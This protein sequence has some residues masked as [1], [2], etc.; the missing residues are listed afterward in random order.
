MGV[1]LHRVYFGY[2]KEIMKTLILSLMLVTSVASAQTL[3]V[4]AVRDWTPTDAP[5]VSQ[6]R[7]YVVT[8]TLDGK[9][10]T[11]QQMF[12]LGSQHFS[13]GMDYEVTKADDRALTVVMHNKKGR[14]VKERLDVTGVE[15]AR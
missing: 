11:T 1:V 8:G 10:Y 15:L 5:R 4:T 3:H 14:E 12:T 7:V 9:L 6:V 13:V 2:Q